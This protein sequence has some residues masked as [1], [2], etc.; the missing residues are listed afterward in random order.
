[1]QRVLDQAGRIVPDLV[2]RGIRR[3]ARQ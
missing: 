2:F 3:L 1:V